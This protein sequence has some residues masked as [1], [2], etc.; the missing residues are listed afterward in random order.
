MN[1]DENLPHNICHKC[2]NRLTEFKS[3]RDCCLKNDELIRLH[4]LIHCDGGGG[5]VEQLDQQLSDSDV[6]NDA[7]VEAV[8]DD[9]LQDIADY[10]RDE[11]Q[12]ELDQK[13]AVAHRGYRLDGTTIV[14]GV[15]CVGVLG[16]IDANNDFNVVQENVIVNDDQSQK[17][18][19]IVNGCA[20]AVAHN[21]IC[22]FNIFIFRFISKSMW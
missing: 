7:I 10:V 6:N 22:Y 21:Y 2:A 16:Y 15:G 19:E 11:L 9:D 1:T 20:A 8:A 17:Q 3:F 12:D 4:S 5:G 18:D 14:D 13:D